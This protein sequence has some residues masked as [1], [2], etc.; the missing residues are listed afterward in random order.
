MKKNMF[1]SLI[2]AGTFALCTA[3]F[4]DNCPI[5]VNTTSNKSYY[6]LSAAEKRFKAGDPSIVKLVPMTAEQLQITSTVS[7]ANRLTLE[8]VKAKKDDY[9]YTLES[10]ADQAIKEAEKDKKGA[11]SKEEEDLPD[12]AGDS[13]KAGNVS[14]YVLSNANGLSFVFRS[15]SLENGKYEIILKPT[16]PGRFSGGEIHFMFEQSSHIWSTTILGPSCLPLN[17]NPVACGFRPEHRRTADGAMLTHITLT[18]DTVYRILGEL[19]M[20]GG[21]PSVWEFSVFRWAKSGCST[22]QGTP[23]DPDAQTY[24]FVPALSESVIDSLKASFAQNGVNQ[25]FHD[26]PKKGNPTKNYFNGVSGHTKDLQLWCDRLGIEPK[27]AYPLSLAE[28]YLGVMPRRIPKPDLSDPEK[29]KEQ[30]FRITEY[31]EE[32][33]YYGKDL[34]DRAGYTSLIDE[35]TRLEVE[36]YINPSAGYNELQWEAIQKRVFSDLFLEDILKLKED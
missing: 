35:L 12:T 11:E 23:R 9:K 34:K 25:F 20:V 22:L 29:T 32:M 21:H 28:Y 10:A 33:T 13:G 30:N 15:T 18:W 36:R 19:P 16:T 2:I 6:D 26:D 7:D 4:A 17:S 14:F 5:I 27:I 3:A 8:A 31:M 1:K 24:L